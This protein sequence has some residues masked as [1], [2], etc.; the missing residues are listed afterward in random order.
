MAA[1][2]LTPEDWHE[3]RQAAQGGMSDSDLALTYNISKNTIKQKRWADKKRGDTWLTPKEVR[4]ASEI[5]EV[6]RKNRTT[7]NGLTNLTGETSALATL[8]SKLA[9]MKEEAP[10]YIAEKVLDL[11][12]KGL[13]GN[14]IPAPKSAKDLSTLAGVFGNMVGIN[15]GGGMVIQVGG[16]AWNSSQAHEKP[17]IVVQ[18]QEA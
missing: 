7:E 15:K 12:K 14:L 6:K 3:L 9:K 16:A 17:V 2:L 4:I 13:D 18:A 8:S 5:E 10:V 1:P 11:I